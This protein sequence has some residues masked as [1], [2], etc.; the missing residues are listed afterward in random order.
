MDAS[1]STSNSQFKKL[2]ASLT[3][4]KNSSWAANIKNQQ[5]FHNPHIFQS[6]I[7]RFGINEPLGSQAEYRTM[8]N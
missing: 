7:E 8:I 4:D 2:A 1:N 3:S 6:V 5:E